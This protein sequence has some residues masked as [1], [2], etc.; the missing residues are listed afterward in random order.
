MQL[1][2]FS[3]SLVLP[4]VLFTALGGSALSAVE[5]APILD[6]GWPKEVAE[7]DATFVVYEPQV[8]A[9]DGYLFEAYSAVAVQEADADAP[10]YGVVSLTAR[11]HV[12]KT[13]RLVTFDQIEVSETRFLSAESRQEA[14][15]G[16]LQKS[17]TDQVRT[18]GLDRVEAGMALLEAHERSQEVPVL[19]EPPAIVFSEKPA[20]LIY[21]DGDP[22]YRAVDETSY[23]RL[24]NT[25]A[26][27][28]R[29]EKGAHWLHMMDGFVTAPA[30]EGPW[31]VAKKTSKK[32]KKAMQLT[33]IEQDAD[34]L[35][36]G[37]PSDE[38]QQKKGKK[39]KA[40][41]K[42]P[43]LKEGPV[44]VVVTATTPTELIV[45]EGEPNYVPIPGTE[46]TY[47]DNTGG[48]VFVHL[49][50]QSLYVLV[51]GRWFRARTAAGPWEHVEQEALP[52]DFAAIP[53]ESPKENVK[54]SVAGTAQAQEALI[55]NSIPETAEVKRGQAEFLP[56]YDG[57]PRLVPIEETDLQRV[58]NSPDPVIRV[59]ETSYYALHDGVWFRASDVDGP[60]VVADEVPAEIYSIPASSPIHNVTYVK[61]YD[62]TPD[63]VVVGY[64]PGYYG[65]VVSD[66]VVVYGTGY[67]YSPWVG[68]YWYGYPMSY[69]WSTGITYSPWA[70]WA[71]TFGVGYSWG[72]WGSSY[73]GP[74]PTPYWGPYYRYPSYYYGG[75][76]VGPRGAVAWGPGGW[77]G[78]T[79]NVYHQWGANTAVTRASGG[80]NA[81]TGNGWRNQVGTSYNS[82]TGTLAAGQRAAVGNV[83]TG[84][85]A[86]GSRGVAG[87]RDAGVAAGRQTATAGNVYSGD[88]VTAS[89]GVV[90]NRNTGNVTRTGSVRGDQGAVGRVGDNVY[91]AKDGSVYKR[92][93]QGGWDQVGGGGQRTS[94]SAAARNRSLEDQY[95]ARYT[96]SQRSQAYS[97]SRH[98]AGSYSRG[99]YAGT[100]GM[101]RGGGRRR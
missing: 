94:T 15:R 11:T 17:F 69:G 2:R 34:L 85:Y 22:V 81:W 41:E 44:P 61:V 70:G 57:E 76:A 56:R 55:A 74:Y 50:D 73:W 87:N 72:Y 60:F 49:R 14:W 79:G 54:A 64:T 90:A 42:P 36:G 5:D 27:I 1:D 92:D 30:L 48:N 20:A 8:E 88:Q 52:D 62:S 91:G 7:G 24:L 82:R 77:A 45:F 33:L 4:M 97:R 66:G 26:L 75:A 98:A 93:G 78:T 84:D 12:D 23:E 35:S 51:S 58:E 99:S 80:Y 6:G 18:I 39:Q 3:C 59:D 16:A 67:S 95:K 37:D 29:D 19:S 46:L 38:R 96:G 13:E 43:S 63:V 71:F 65:T 10:V 21:V 28:L 47:A 89:R 25:R 101:R 9:W 83:Y 31:S 68:S 86:Y 32:L 100:G 53:D 40:K